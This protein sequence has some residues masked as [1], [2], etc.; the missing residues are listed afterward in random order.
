MIYHLC[1]RGREPNRFSGADGFVEKRIDLRK[2]QEG[3]KTKGAWAWLAFQL[4]SKGQFKLELLV[5]VVSG[6]EWDF[7]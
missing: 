2:E 4:V 3:R 1:P 5:S 6:G 7:V